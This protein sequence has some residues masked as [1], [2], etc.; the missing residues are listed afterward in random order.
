MCLQHHLSYTCSVRKHGTLLYS[1]NGDLSFISHLLYKST[2]TSRNDEVKAQMGTCTVS[3]TTEPCNLNE[4][5][6]L[7]HKEIRRFLA[8]DLNTPYPFHA[9]NIERL[10]SEIDP[11]LWAFIK[12]ITRTIS[13]THGYS[14][15]ANQPQTLQHHVKQV[16]RLFCL[17]A[18]MFCT[19]D[20]CSFPFHTL[21]TD[22]IESGV[23]SAQLIRILNRMGIC[24]SADTLA[25]SIQYR[26]KEREIR[27]PEE[28]CMR[29]IPTIISTDNIDFQHS[30]ARVFCGKQVS[31][32]HGTTVQAVQPI[33]HAPQQHSPMDEDIPG[34]ENVEALPCPCSPS[35]HGQCTAVGVSDM[36]ESNRHME[37]ALPENIPM[38]SRRKHSISIRSPHK[39]TRLAIPK[40]KR[41]ARTGTEGHF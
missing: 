31:S 11:T 12:S 3:S 9:L 5:N 1:S 13:E 2:H 39:P 19:D 17:S 28:D 6:C 38:L 18:L 34:P 22:A 41:C 24:S 16:R 30:Y 20:R 25:R 14:T 8:T 26:V 35:T 23:G 21:I 27:G 37:C 7:L 10:V 33:L 4:L 32:W 15:K 36:Q 40:T 29:N